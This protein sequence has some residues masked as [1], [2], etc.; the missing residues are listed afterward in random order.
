M[1][2]QTNI[3]QA[4]KQKL[5]N[6]KDYRIGI[7]GAGFI[8]QECHL[9][10]YQ[11]LG[12]KPAAICS[13]VLD[14][15]MAVAEKNGITKVYE[16]WKQLINDS[17]IEVLDIAVPPHVQLEIV[18]Y[19]CTKSHI[20]AIQCQ[21]P[22]STNYEDALEIARI[23]K[24]SGVL[25]SVNSNMRFDQSIRALKY[26]LDRGLLGRPV[27]ASLEQRAI[28][29]WQKFIEKY[30]RLTF[31]NFSIH[32]I[33]S[34]RYLFGNPHSI[35]ALCTT[36]PRLN[37]KHTDGITQFTYQ[38]ENGLMATSL[39]DTYVYPGEP[40][41][42]DSYIKWRVEGTEGVAKG[43]IGWTEFPELCPSRLMLTSKA[44]PNQW[45]KPKW[46]TCWFPD[47][48]GGTMASLLYALENNAEPEMSASDNVVTIACVEACYLSLKEKRTVLLEEII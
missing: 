8:V 25:I 19:A 10:A 40:C 29:H 44:Y 14:E 37:F 20:K 45:I 32:E 4:I 33:D 13:L 47:A 1:S 24:Q 2:I 18:K 12:F 42:K 48:F 46:N 43:T 21:K 31:L 41:E 3:E 5:P 27:L 38:Y 17:D 36:D 28:P 7:I 23:G 39:D 16:E 22:L 15:S 26:C 9:P 6:R 30:E 11:K 35:T 34:F